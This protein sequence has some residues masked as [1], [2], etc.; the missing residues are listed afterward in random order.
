MAS[1]IKLNFRSLHPSAYYLNPTEFERVNVRT[2]SMAPNSTIGADTQKGVLPG[3]LVKLAGDRLTGVFE[4]NTTTPVIGMFTEPS[5]APPFSNLGAAG[6]GVVPFVT[7]PCFV[8]VYL[9]ET[10]SPLAGN[11]SIL[12]AYTVGAKLYAGV[13]GLLSNQA[14]STLSAS[15]ASGVD[16]VVGY[17]V[18]PPTATN[19]K[20]EV[21]LWPKIV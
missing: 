10:H 18:S 7:A 1:L 5:E 12:S 15:Y 16:T 8:T 11:A 19:L 2:G 9:F 13:Y 6:S 20:M 4:Y 21:F 14:P 17:V 3:H